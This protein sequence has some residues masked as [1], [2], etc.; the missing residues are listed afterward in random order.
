MIGK[1]LLWDCRRSQIIPKIT[2]FKEKFFFSNMKQKGK[3]TRKIIFK[4]NGNSLQI[5]KMIR[6]LFNYSCCCFLYCIF[7]VIC[8]KY[9]INNVNFFILNTK[10]NSCMYFIVIFD[11]CK[12]LLY[13]ILVSLMLFLK[14]SS[15]FQVTKVTF[16]DDNQYAGNKLLITAY[17]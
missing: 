11:C 15:L 13:L 8:I 9:A 14:K 3:S 10:F 16:T 4:R 1:L 7:S 17:V 6:L 2:R 5:D 12:M